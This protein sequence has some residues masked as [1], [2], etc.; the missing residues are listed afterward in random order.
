MGFKA[1]PQQA[2][3]MLSI[4]FGTTDEE[5]RPKM[6]KWL[7]P[8][9]HREELQKIGLI[10]LERQGRGQRVLLTEQ[11]WA[12]AAENLNSVLPEKNRAA[13]V[14]EHVLRRLDAQ[15]TNAGSSLAHFVAVPAANDQGVSVEAPHPALEESVSGT[16]QLSQRI[17]TAALEIAGGRRA[18]R[19]R[20]RDLRPRLKDIPRA[21]LDREL[22][23]LQ[24]IGT[25]V[26]YRI[27]DPIDISAED[28]S[29]ALHVAGF[30]RHILYLQE[31]RP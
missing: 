26:L 19:V 13:R 18:T 27:D 29:A 22:L 9:R 28:V 2:L 20:L 6:S 1:N 7:E 30:P 16:Q 23:E 11:G 17:E 31:R 25:L 15:L 24:R 3:A 10:R 8:K 21:V 4:V 12:W 14:L 5:I